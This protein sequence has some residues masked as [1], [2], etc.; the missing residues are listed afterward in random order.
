MFM[1]TLGKRNNVNAIPEVSA[2]KFTSELANQRVRKA[3]L[4]CVVYSNTD[5]WC[6]I[7]DIVIQAMIHSHLFSVTFLPC[8]DSEPRK[9]VVK[10]IKIWS[11]RL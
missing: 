6:E 10:I 7:L 9:L 8:L 1:I 11:P 5:Y 3:P 4:T 2:I